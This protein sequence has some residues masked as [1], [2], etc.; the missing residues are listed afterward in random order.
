[1][2]V[3]EADYN[4]I[5]DQVK[6]FNIREEYRLNRIFMKIGRISMKS[7][8]IILKLANKNGVVELYENINGEECVK[9]IKV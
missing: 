8:R 5:V 7:T 2:N 6:T 4:H 3:E 9:F 1:M